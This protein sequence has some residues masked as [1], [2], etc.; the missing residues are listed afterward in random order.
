[1][2]LKLGKDFCKCHSWDLQESVC[3]CVELPAARSALRVKG[4]EQLRILMK[5][6]KPIVPP[7]CCAERHAH[8]ILAFRR[9]EGCRRI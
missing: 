7:S 3:G 8:S 5:I 1:M 9:N 6:K 2:H 4:I